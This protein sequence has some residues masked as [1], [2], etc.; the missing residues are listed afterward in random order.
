M[1]QNEEISS[2]RIGSQQEPL[3]TSESRAPLLVYSEA[4]PIAL[5]GQQRL[6]LNHNAMPDAI[7]NKTQILA[8]SDDVY[9]LRLQGAGVDLELC[10]AFLKLIGRGH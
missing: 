1:L 3:Y 5:V 7:A 8:G 6:F 4:K 9:D 10:D 2:R